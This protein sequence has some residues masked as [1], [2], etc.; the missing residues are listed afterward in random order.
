M[1][2]WHIHEGPP[3]R[4]RGGSTMQEVAHDLLEIHEE[5]GLS[6]ILIDSKDTPDECSY[7]DPRMVSLH[8]VIPA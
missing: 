8:G 2:W 3:Y 6:V 4:C 1:V 7:R 5:G